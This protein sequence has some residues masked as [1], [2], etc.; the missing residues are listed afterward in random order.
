[1]EKIINASVEAINLEEET[2]LSSRR[3]F[4]KLSSAAVLTAFAC[5]ALNP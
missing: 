2:S 1:M 3:S 4:I 5:G